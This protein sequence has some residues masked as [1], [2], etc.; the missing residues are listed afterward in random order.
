M[1]DPSIQTGGLLFEWVQSLRVWEDSKTF[2]DSLP[3]VCPPQI[4][5]EFHAFLQAYATENPS[6]PAGSLDSPLAF[7]Q[8]VPDPAQRESLVAELKEFLLHKFQVQPYSMEEHIETM[9]QVL[10]RRSDDLPPNTTLISLPNPYIVAGGRYL[11]SY[12]WDS[13]FTSLGLAISGRGKTL[14]GMVE[15]FASLIRRLGYIPNGTRTYYL[16]RSQ[17]P[18]FSHFLE[19]LEVTQGAASALAFADDLKNEYDFW[20]DQNTSA[21]PEMTSDRRC[22]QVAGAQLNRYWDD[23]ASP[24]PEGFWEDIQTAAAAQVNVEG[25]KRLYRHLRAAAES[26]WDFSSRWI[27]PRVANNASTVRYSLS[28]IRTTEILPVDLNAMLFKMEGQLAHLAELRGDAQSA[29]YYA[30][31]AAARK[32]ALLGLCWNAQKG[33]FFD[34]HI[35][36]QEQTQ[37]WSL[38]GIHPLYCKMLDANN[39][40][41]LA[42]V[43]QVRQNLLER[44]L[45]PGGV[46]TTLLECG[47]QWDSPNG[48]APL[49]WVAVVGLLNY[50]YEEEAAEIAARFVSLARKTY[51]ATGKMMEKYDVCDLSRPG[52]GGEYPNQEGFGWTNGVVTGFAE[53]LSAG[54]SSLAG[55]LAART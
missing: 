38:A 53:L 15:N 44:F 30:E 51:A 24:R 37:V 41:E 35:P 16:G 48:W 23:N 21:N 4:E 32:A 28:A 26:G 29:A 8:A 54:R 10:E 47:Q 31:L 12:Y 9:W 6:L 27:A 55:Q 13:Y 39:P 5:R 3:L 34:Y 33:W 18:Y 40:Q 22:V 42:I 52:G 14:L 43:R 49:Q 1:P 2:P 46:V 19:L 7:L 11:E 45:K 17:P 20:M 25:A 50:G 36:G